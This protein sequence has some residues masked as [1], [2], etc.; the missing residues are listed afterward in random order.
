[1]IQVMLLTCKL[2]DPRNIVLQVLHKLEIYVD[3]EIAKDLT[4]NNEESKEQFYCN[5]IPKL[6]QKLFLSS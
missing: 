1:M 6:R 5:Y 4:F 2:V 3:D